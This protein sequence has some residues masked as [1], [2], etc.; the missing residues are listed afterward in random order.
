MLFSVFVQKVASFLT[1]TADH[2]IVKL[3]SQLLL[4]SCW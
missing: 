4:I 3:L 2:S 1:L